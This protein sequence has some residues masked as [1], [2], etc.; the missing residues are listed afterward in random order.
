VM[1]SEEQFTNLRAMKRQLP[2]GDTLYFAFN[3]GYDTV[4]THVVIPDSRSVCMLRAV[5]GS[6]VTVNAE[7]TA[8]G[9]RLPV[10]LPSGEIAVFLFGE[11]VACAEAD[12]TLQPRTTV[13]ALTEFTAAKTAQFLL[14]ER[15]MD[16]RTIEEPEVPVELGAWPCSPDFSGVMR[17]RTT[18]QLDRNP[19]GTAMLKLGRVCYSAR[20]FVNGRD[21]GICGMEPNHIYFDAAL[22]NKGTNCIEIEVSNTAANAY[23]AFPAREYWEERYLSGYYDRERKFELDSLESGLFGPVTLHIS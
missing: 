7:Q 17:Y 22:L 10:E 15:G 12:H 2:N 23:V 18:V 16:F 3:E 20:L 11:G 14:N 6:I 8:E 9:T 1:Q 13:Y 21:A 5:D 4:A 19:D